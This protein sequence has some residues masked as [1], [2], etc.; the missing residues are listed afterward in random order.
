MQFSAED[1][2]EILG[3]MLGFFLLAALFVVLLSGL[4]ERIGCLGQVGLFSIFLLIGALTSRY[5]YLV[6]PLYL[7][8][9]AVVAFAARSKP[10]E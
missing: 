7:V 1:E 9:Q 6:L 10:R 3:L 2:R 5:F 4:P 8:T